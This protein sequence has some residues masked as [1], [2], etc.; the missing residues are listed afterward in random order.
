VRG[1]NATTNAAAD[2][3]TADWALLLT[4][5]DAKVMVQLIAAILTYCNSSIVGDAGCVIM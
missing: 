2:A 3:A 1:L 4:T 5:C